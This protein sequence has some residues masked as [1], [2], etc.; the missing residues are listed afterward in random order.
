MCTNPYCFKSTLMVGE[1]TFFFHSTAGIFQDQKENYTTIHSVKNNKSQ[2][3][4]QY[5][6]TLTFAFIQLTFYD[7]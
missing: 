4:S 3:Q 5:Q 2:L 1:K 6:S 7:Q